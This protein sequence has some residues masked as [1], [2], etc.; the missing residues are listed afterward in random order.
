MEAVVGNTLS[1]VFSLSLSLNTFTGVT[2]LDCSVKVRCNMNRHKTGVLIPLQEYPR[3]PLVGHVEPYDVGVI[4]TVRS[5]RTN[6][7]KI[8]KPD[9][10]DQVTRSCDWVNRSRRCCR[11]STTR[12]TRTHDLEISNLT[13][14]LV[15]RIKST[16]RR[17]P[18]WRMPPLCEIPTHSCGAVRYETGPYVVHCP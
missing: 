5:S 18:C 14:L 2:I 11:N 1:V 6:C 10:V 4:G 15:G 9:H 13:G 12:G 16:A 7:T 8:G 17:A 3:E